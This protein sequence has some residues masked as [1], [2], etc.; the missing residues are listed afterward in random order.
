MV[1]RWPCPPSSSCSAVWQYRELSAAA[2]THA[3]SFPLSVGHLCSGF[4]PYS[5]NALFTCIGFPSDPPSVN[6]SLKGEA[7][8]YYL[9]FPIYAYE[10]PGLELYWEILRADGETELYTVVNETHYIETYEEYTERGVETYGDCY[11]ACIADL[12][13]SPTDLKYDG[14][15]VT[16]VLDLPGCFNS[17][18]SSDTM[19]LNIQGHNIN[20]ARVVLLC[21]YE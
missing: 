19:M 4:S 20:I 8:F 15:Q 14:A 7:S 5:S 10:C 9:A 18:N 6:T 13:I 17:S 16:V 3:R 12:R 2:A 11:G 1:R 21:I